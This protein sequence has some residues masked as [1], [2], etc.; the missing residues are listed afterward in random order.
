MGTEL[1]DRLKRAREEAGFAD[2]VSAAAALGANKFTYGQHENGTRGFKR[3]TA[4]TYARRFRVNLEWLLTGRG[5]MRAKDK[6]LAKVVG[7]VGAGAAM[8]LYSDGQE[9]DEWVEAPDGST[10]DTVAVE[11][12]GE[13]LGPIFDSWLVFYDDRR[14][15]VTRDM[16]GKLCILGLADGRVLIKKLAKGGIAGYW[17]LLS[18]FDPP[19]Y[20]VVLEWGA[21]VKAMVPR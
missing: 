16:L 4:T 7:C 12:K 19:I 6:H 20:D 21:V 11:V 2:A 17:T 3:D 1:G 15:P 10:A 5:P 9:P 14:D 18:N 13:S 8:V